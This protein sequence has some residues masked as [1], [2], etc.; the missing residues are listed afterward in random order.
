LHDWPRAAPILDDEMA[1]HERLNSVVV[2]AFRP[3]HP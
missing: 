1:E 2:P 3:R